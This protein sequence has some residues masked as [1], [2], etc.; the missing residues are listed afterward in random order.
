MRFL[1]KPL[2]DLA[3]WLTAPPPQANVPLPDSAKL[4]QQ[5]EVTV[6][7]LCPCGSK[8]PQRLSLLTS[9]ECL[10]CGRT[11]AIRSFQYMRSHYGEI[12]NPSVSVGYLHTDDSLSRRSTSGVH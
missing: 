9:A 10:R 7:C 1:T 6:M 11:M 8:L 2:T 5:V 12:P 4:I 3:R